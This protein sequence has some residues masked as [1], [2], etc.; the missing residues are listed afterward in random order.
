MGRKPRFG[1]NGIDIQAAVWDAIDEIG[2]KSV[3]V[4]RSSSF[5]EDLLG[6][7]NPGT[8]DD[9]RSYIMEL[10]PSF[11]KFDPDFRLEVRVAGEDLELTVEVRFNAE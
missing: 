7:I 5:K 8:V 4:E 6:F 3:V 9:F 1:K 11:F 10:F 2:D